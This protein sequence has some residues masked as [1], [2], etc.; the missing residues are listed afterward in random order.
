M[1]PHCT[2]C[3]LTLWESLPKL[4]C[5]LHPPSWQRGSTGCLLAF[6]K[7]SCFLPHCYPYR[8]IYC[9][10]PWKEKLDLGHGLAP[11]CLEFTNDPCGKAGRSWMCSGNN[12]TNV[13]RVSIRE[14]FQMGERTIWCPEPIGNN[15]YEDSV[16]LWEGVKVQLELAMAAQ[17]RVTALGLK[18]QSRR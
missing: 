7:R 8:R 10:Y 14:T 6:L 15:M 3:H 2:R 12:R 9:K 11:F 5:S 13:G 17:N 16:F 1:N 4:L 18:R